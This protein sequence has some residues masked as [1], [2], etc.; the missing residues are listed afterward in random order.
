MRNHS[1]NSVY[2]EDDVTLR[3]AIRGRFDF[4]MLAEFR[5]AY[6]RI[7]AEAQSVIIDMTHTETIDSSAL[8]MLLNMQRHLNKGDREI[9]IINCNEDVRNI[10][11]IT[12][13]DRKFDIS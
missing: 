4:S 5:E 10:F 8:G 12:R 11:D 7:E 2:H 13:F 9:R 1:V 6:S 3:I